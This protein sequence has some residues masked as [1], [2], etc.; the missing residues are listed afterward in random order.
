MD[1]DNRR[2][3]KRENPPVPMLATCP[4]CRGPMAVGGGRCIQCRAN[5]LLDPS[6]ESAAAYVGLIVDTFHKWGLTGPGEEVQS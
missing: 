6:H 1:S 2:S 5:T 3:D 4:R